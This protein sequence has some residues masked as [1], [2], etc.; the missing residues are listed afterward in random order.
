MDEALLQL[1]R[2]YRVPLVPIPTKATPRTMRFDDIQAVVFD[3]YGTLLISGSGD[4]G[5]TG[6]ASSQEH[7]AREALRA[8]GIDDPPPGKAVAAG[9]HEAI[10]LDHGHRQAD[11]EEFPEVDIVHIWHTVVDQLRENELLPPGQ[12]DGER[13]AVE[14]ELR[15]NPVDVM[16]GA[17]QLLDQLQAAEMVLGVV[18]N[19]QF[20]TPIF[21]AAAFGRTITEMGFASD[22]QYYSYEHRRA[23]PGTY[24]YQLAADAL[25]ARGIAP[26]QVLYVGNDIRNDI[27]PAR[28]VGFR[29]AL[30]A[31]DRRSL[32]LRTDDP[33][34]ATIQPNIVI[35]HLSQ[36]AEVVGLS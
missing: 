35:S 21:W 24:L 19:A 17:A 9:L 36:L 15:A 22:V 6:A 33:K 28:Q 10:A 31:G 1:A 29:T 7:A 5:S 27:W 11:G 30:F 12:V 20:F 16:P 2:Q 4:V 34:M 8:M 3:I 23:K 26:P 14:Y 32:R 13:L 18:S 25:A